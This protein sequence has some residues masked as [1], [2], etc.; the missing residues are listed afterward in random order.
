MTAG[1]YLLIRISHS[2]ASNPRIALRLL[3][4]RT[5]TIIISGLRA[6]IETDIKKVIALSTLRQ[7]G[8]IITRLSLNLP[9]LALFHIITHALFKSLLFI[10]AGTLISIN[11]HFQDIRSFGQLLHS[12]PITASSALISLLALSGIPFLAGFY[13]KDTIIETI[14]TSRTSRLII[15]LNLIGLGLTA[16]YSLRIALI[17]F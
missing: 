1:V 10:T 11:R 14:I 2:I 16:G 4:L 7:L 5:S 15:S 6:L 17:L 9:Q 3:V 12:Y 8:I 13:S